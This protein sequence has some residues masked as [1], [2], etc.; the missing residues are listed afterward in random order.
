[1]SLHGWETRRMYVVTDRDTG[2]KREF[3]THR[4]AMEECRRIDARGHY[5]ALASIPDQSRSDQ[6]GE[7]STVRPPPTRQRPS[8]V[9]PEP[10]P[11]VRP[12]DPCVACGEPVDPPGFPLV[13]VPPNKIPILTAVHEICRESAES[14]AEGLDWDDLRRTPESVQRALGGLQAQL[15]LQVEAMRQFE[16]DALQRWFDDSG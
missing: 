11:G 15:A 8:L 12:G 7:R 16:I 4:E 5:W 6:P 10:M 2:E 14:A 3:A 9:V 13:L 1:M